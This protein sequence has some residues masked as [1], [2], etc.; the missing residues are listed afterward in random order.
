MLTEEYM[1]PFIRIP[2]EKMGEFIQYFDSFNYGKSML[3]T[4]PDNGY[5]YTD[6]LRYPTVVLFSINIIHYI[7]GD[8]SSEM[9]RILLRKIPQMNIVLADAKWL[10][11]LQ[12]C[13]PNLEK[14]TRK[15]F[16]YTKSINYLE[17]FIEAIPDGY[18]LRRMNEGDITSEVMINEIISKFFKDTN[19]FLKNGISF[20]I[21]H[22][23]SLTSF[24]CS[25][26]EIDKYVDIQIETKQEYRRN[27]LATALGAKITQFALKNN[28]IPIWVSMNE[29]SSLL[30]EKIG[31][32]DPTPFS[33]YYWKE[34]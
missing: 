21:F 24:A 26:L 8:Y 20:G 14:F 3:E 33:M 12:D 32:S 29:P 22:N 15:E 19:Q 13:W 10:P 31:Y 27:G 11:N 17:S 7:T 6:N 18:V 2:N 1:K 23:N 16:K 34:E 28:L 4:I 5:G 25:V 30:A 9:A